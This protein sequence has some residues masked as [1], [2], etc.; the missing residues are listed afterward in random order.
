MRILYAL[1]YKDTTRPFGVFVSSEEAEFEKTLVGRPSEI[2]EIPT[3][4]LLLL[5]IE[6]AYEQLVRSSSNS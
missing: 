6:K 3:Y 4:D 5:K 2:I 1:F